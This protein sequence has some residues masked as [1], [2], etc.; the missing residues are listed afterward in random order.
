M[1]LFSFAFVSSAYSGSGSGTENDPFLITTCSQLQEVRNYAGSAYSWVYWEVANNIDCSDTVNWNNGW[2]FLIIGDA[3]TDYPNNYFFEGHFDGKGYTIS[4]L[5]ING[6]GR[7]NVSMFADV[8]GTL[9]NINLENI[10]VNNYGTGTANDYVGGFFVYNEGGTID[11]CN[12][13]GTVSGGD[14]LG[15]MFAENWGT[16]TNSHFSGTVN[17]VDNVGGLG[18]SSDTGTITNCYSTGT[19]NSVLGGVVGGLIGN[20]YPDTTIEYSYS[21]ADVTFLSDY[22]GGLVGLVDGGTILNSYA[23]GSVTGGSYSAG[24]VGGCY[25]N[26]ERVGQINNSYSTGAVTGTNTGGLVGENDGIISNSFWDTETSGQ[27]ISAGG[28]GKT[29]S[30]MKDI[31]TFSNAGWTITTTGSNE[32]N[33]YPFLLSGSWVIYQSQGLIQNILGSRPSKTDTLVQQEQ[34]PTDEQA[35]VSKVSLFSGIKNWFQSIIDWFKGLFN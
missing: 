29:T 27:L 10:N 5:Y 12:V 25:T 26:G 21:T 31:T 3:Y 33:G 23:T 15:G 2:G 28:T 32:N 8:K 14:W 18:G 7:E 4:D 22:G 30:E 17:G 34:L 20:V 13:S 9:Q 19:V 24:L 16:I 11:N 35:P 6:T 1:F